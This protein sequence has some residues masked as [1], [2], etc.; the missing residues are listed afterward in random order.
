MI[1]TITMQSPERKASEFLNH[2]LTQKNTLYPLAFLVV[3]AYIDTLYPKSLEL[4]MRPHEL[5]PLSDWG[6]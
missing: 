4:R 6:E 1:A 2:Q 3:D 5:S